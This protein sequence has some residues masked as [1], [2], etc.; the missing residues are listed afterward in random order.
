MGEEGSYFHRIYKLIKGGFKRYREE[1][2]GFKWGLGAAVPFFFSSKFAVHDETITIYG[3]QIT[4]NEDSPIKYSIVKISKLGT[5]IEYFDSVT[6]YG[7]SGG[8]DFNY[9]FTVPNGTGY[10]LEIFNYFHYHA[11]GSVR[12]LKKELP[13]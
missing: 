13:S 2:G 6:F 5:S 1:D 11:T 4:H 10:Q 7:D 8:E 12:M 9:T 3:F